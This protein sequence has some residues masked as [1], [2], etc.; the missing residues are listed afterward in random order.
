M[1]NVD[2]D[3][4][5]HLT[6]I[7]VGLNNKIDFSRSNARLTFQKSLDELIIMPTLH[8]T[9][10]S[11]LGMPARPKIMASRTIQDRFIVFDN[12]NTLN[13]WNSMSGQL[14]SSNKFTEKDYT[15]YVI[16][17]FKS[18]DILKKKTMHDKTMDNSMS[19]SQSEESEKEEEEEENDEEEEENE[20]EEVKEPIFREDK[21]YRLGFDNFTLIRSKAP[22]EDVNADDFFSESQFI[23]GA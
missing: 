21:A 8:R 10:I 9:T 7:Q 19:E 18:E 16:H 2:S 6:N 15:K 4:S 23:S 12:A 14:L 11:F 3:N 13:T 20:P 5:Y 22:C 1:I 17:D